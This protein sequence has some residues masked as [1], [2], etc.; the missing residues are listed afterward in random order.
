MSRR[1][2]SL[3]L[4]LLAVLAANAKDKKKVVLPDYVLKARTVLIV[5]NPEAGTSL[6]NPNAN[7]IAQQDVEKAIMNWGR[8]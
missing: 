7:W 1:A 8:L 6:Q 4:L 2:L 3:T 5:I